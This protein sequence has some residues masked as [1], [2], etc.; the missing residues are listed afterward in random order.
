MIRKKVNKED[1]INKLY[2]GD[3]LNIMSGFP[4]NSIDCIVTS[5]PYWKQRD[6]GWS[7]QWGQEP[8]FEE[9]LQHLHEFMDEANRILKKEGTIW[10][11]LGDKYHKGNLLMLP[12]R[13]A[14]MCQDSG[15]YIRNDIV[16]AKCLSGST[17]LYTKTD[18]GVQKMNIKDIARRN[19]V[20]KIRL[21]NGDKWVRIKGIYE[22]KKPK[23][24]KSI[25]LRSGDEIISTDN[26]RYPTI[27]G[28]KRTD[29][30]EIGDELIRCKL[31]DGDIKCPNLDGY[32]G[33][34]IGMYIAEGSKSKTTIQFSLS[35]SE[36]NYHERIEAIS[37][38]FH[39][40]YREH[41]SDGDGITIMINSP[42]I[43][44]II[45]TYVDG[46]NSHGKHFS[47]KLWD[48]DNEFLQNI[49]IGYLDGDGHY[50]K[51]KNRYRLGFTFNPSL[52]NDLITICNRLG[53]SI[54]LKKGKFKESKSG[55]EFL[56]YRGQ[57]RFKESIFKDNINEN[58]IIKICKPLGAPRKFWDIELY[59]DPHLFSLGSGILTHNS[60]AMPDGAANRLTVVHEYFF[61][62]TK[63][64]SGYYFDL[65]SIRDKHKE[66]SLRRACRSQFKTGQYAMN[67]VQNNVG[68]DDMYDLLKQGKL[69]KLNK[70]GRNPTTVQQFWD[71]YNKNEELIESAIDLFIQRELYSTLDDT[72][73]GKNPFDH[74]AT[75][76]PKLI[77]K[78]VKAG[79]PK[80]GIILDPF[81]GTASTLAKAIEC[82]RQFI[83]IDGCEIFINL[84]EKVL[85]AEIKKR[86]GVIKF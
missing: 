64:K 4:E 62:I 49:L 35:K 71:D 50:D 16:W 51:D 81:C 39:G 6:Y 69:K 2:V 54:Y 80:G 17:M 30:L 48:R 12:H 61:L 86:Q 84:S 67:R 65:D 72:P 19:D 70:I 43:D 63:I 55:K 58:Q 27:Y 82:D 56:G 52:A 36:K 5:P 11:N 78:P 79:C 9:Y 18:N 22:N 77:E 34:L 53:Y 44:S 75:Y 23:N 42:V 60:N 45:N 10:I 41:N 32:I 59:D 31:P 83:G 76:N 68:Y 7:G 21:W 25:I 3:C 28:L 24:V 8:T 13:F 1:F 29:E 47:N 57:I 74:Y 73:K 38:S 20:D 66:S 37:R 33:W 40:T 26:H 85:K 46:K 14:I 15:W